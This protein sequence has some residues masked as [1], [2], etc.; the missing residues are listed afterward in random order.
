[1]PRASERDALVAARNLRI[2]GTV[3]LSPECTSNDL[4]E[5]YTFHINFVV[6][7]PGSLISKCSL[8][9]DE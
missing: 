8:I 1:M 7:F 2:R 5:L 4:A 6:D 3:A 9:T